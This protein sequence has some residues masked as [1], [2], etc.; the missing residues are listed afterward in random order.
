MIP[1]VFAAFLVIL[2]T[3]FCSVEDEVMSNKKL[4]VYVDDK[5]LFSKINSINI[6]DNIYNTSFIMCGKNESD[7]SNDFNHCLFIEF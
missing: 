6:G 7:T 3:A 4:V 2:L 5:D 1:K